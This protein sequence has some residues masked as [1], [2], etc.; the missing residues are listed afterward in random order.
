MS[1]SAARTGPPRFRSAE[2]RPRVADDV[3]EQLA[4]AILRGQLA[5]GARLP[6]E[7]LLGARFKVSRIIVRQAVH[8]LAELGLVAARQGGHTVVLDPRQSTS[9]GVLELEYRLGP[10][11]PR[12]VYDFTER[13]IMQGH[14]ILYIA[15]RRASP[16]QLRRLSAIVDDYEAEGGTAEGMP[17]FEERFWRALAA[18]SGNRLYQLESNWWF[19]L[20]ARHPR[21]Q[22]PVVA[23]PRVRLAAFRE[24][25]RRLEDRE[26]AA[27]L[28]LELSSALLASLT[29]A[30][31]QPPADDRAALVEAALEAEQIARSL[32]V[33]KE[34]RAS[35]RR[36]RPRARTNK[37]RE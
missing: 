8:K 33:A 9:L 2:R 24:L 20:L 30:P 11:S 26:D 7:R 13:Q 17:D 4:R 27:E 34:L 15:Q 37:I 5:V 14:A 12:D 1:E 21:S 22:H 29:H 28:W 25:V 36:R 6:S 23:P 18:A 16:A 3:F 10:G 31:V 19:S 35:R 32:E